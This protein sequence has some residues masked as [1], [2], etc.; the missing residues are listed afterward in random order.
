MEIPSVQLKLQ[1]KQSEL[2]DLCENS[3]YTT[4]GYGGSRGGGK[5]GAL[6]RIMLLRRLANPGTAGLIF[7][8]VYD[9]LKRNHIDKFFEEFPS[10][11]RYYR[12]TDHEVVL[13]AVGGNPPSRI[14]F[15]YAETEAEVRRKFHGVEYMDMFIDQAEQ[16]SEVEMKV[17]KTACRWPGTGRYKCKFVLFFNPG[18]I[19]IVYLK[20]IFSDRNFRE[21]ERAGEYRFIQAYGW[22][23]VE[24]ARSSLIESGLDEEDFYSWNAE[25][26]FRYFIDETQYGQELDALPQALRIGYLMGSFDT[27]AGQYFDIWNEEL[28]TIREDEL[29]IE[30]WHPKWVS[31]DWG[32]SHDSAVYWWAQD[33]GVTKTYREL[34]SS[35]IGPRALAQEII[36]RSSM[37]ASEEAGQIDAIYISPDSKQ[38]R[39][40]EDT[41]IDQMAK[42]FTSAGMP[43]PR[44]ADDHRVSGWVL[45]HEMLRYNQW[46]IGKNCPKL[47]ETIPLFSRDDKNP[48][49]CLKFVGDDPGDSAR[50]GLKSRFA[51]REPPK[52]V[53]FATAM[54]VVEKKYEETLEKGAM[55]TAMHMAHLRFMQ[56]WAKKH[57]PV[58]RIR[59]WRPNP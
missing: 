5:S 10:L 54:T 16:L 22:D 9:D 1:P 25:E 39:T 50:Y 44:I 43:R 34:V 51:R 55:H 59:K 58:R 26:R 7:R 46:K 20:R 14:V 45:M 52:E 29:N 23:N 32:F 28:Q 37:F 53:Q 2:L 35:G 49:D 33:G 8:R 31:I 3:V 38:K 6:R 48:E 57:A 11:L 13:P 4:I 47:I 15:G 30:P 17:M 12:A 41:I 40:T 42:V 19:G 21:K 27:F 18:G 56:D 36:D 24:W